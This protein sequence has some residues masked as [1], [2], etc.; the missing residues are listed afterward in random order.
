M[1]CALCASAADQSNILSL[2]L[3]DTG[4]GEGDE[5][6]RA[7]VAECVGRLALLPGGHGVV[8]EALAGRLTSPQAHMRQLVSIT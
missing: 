5:E 3:G 2:L 1:H 8:L 6:C 7:L 4:A